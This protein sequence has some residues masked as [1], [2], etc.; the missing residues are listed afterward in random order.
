M[1]VVFASRGMHTCRGEAKFDHKQKRLV[2][3]TI[4]VP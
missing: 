1:V 4:I 2:S 3:V